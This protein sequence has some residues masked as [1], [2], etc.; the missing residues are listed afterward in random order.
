MC[1]KQMALNNIWIQNIYMYKTIEAN[2]NTAA[3]PTTGKSCNLYQG[4]A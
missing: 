3:I 4:I 1:R 2:A